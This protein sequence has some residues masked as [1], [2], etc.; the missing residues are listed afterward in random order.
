MNNTEAF[1]MWKWRKMSK[2]S[3]MEKVPNNEVLERVEVE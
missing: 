3:L 1:E 2:I